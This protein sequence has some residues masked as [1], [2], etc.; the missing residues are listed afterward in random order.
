MLSSI[1][2][3]LVDIGTGA[4]QVLLGVVVENAGEWFFH[5]YVLHGLGRRPGSMW[6]YH[7]H[8]HHRLARAHQMLD[9]DYQGWPLHWNTQGKEA[10]FLLS[11]IALHL[12]LIAWFPGYVA[13]MFLGLAV[14]YVKHRK[15]HLDADWAKVRLPWHYEHHLSAGVEGNWCVSWPWFDWLMGT[16]IHPASLARQRIPGN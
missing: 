4:L 14:Y 8:E 6:A 16:R 5:R 7:W 11:I 9:P 10:L 12:P 3:L 1:V 2:A 13:G 15:A